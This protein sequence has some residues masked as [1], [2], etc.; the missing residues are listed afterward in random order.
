MSYLPNDAISLA[1]ISVE[2]LVPPAVGDGPLPLVYSGDA[3]A[4]GM[5]SF[6]FKWDQLFGTASDDNPLLTPRMAARIH[7]LVGLATEDELRDY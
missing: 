7:S 5:P 1:Y 3:H 2:N 4:V 6:E